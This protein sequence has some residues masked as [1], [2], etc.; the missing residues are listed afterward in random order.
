MS[1]ALV[2]EAGVAGIEEGA[3]R[4]RPAA[5]TLATS[6]TGMTVILRAGGRAYP[7]VRPGGAEAPLDAAAQVVATTVRVA[8]RPARARLLVVDPT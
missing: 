8:T 1:A 4:L 2:A 6:V 3:A 5:R 7:E